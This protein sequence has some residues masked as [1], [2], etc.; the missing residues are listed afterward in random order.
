MSGALEPGKGFAGKLR[1]GQRGYCRPRPG[2]DEF[3]GFVLQMASVAWWRWRRLLDVA[4]GAGRL[5]MVA[6]TPSFFGAFTKAGRPL[7]VV[8]WPTVFLNSSLIALR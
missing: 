3:T 8:P 6:V 4:D 2:R 1:A 7:H 5:L